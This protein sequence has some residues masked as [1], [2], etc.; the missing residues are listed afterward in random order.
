[1]NTPAIESR[2]PAWN[3][4]L[5]DDE[6]DVIEV[7]RMVMEDLVFEDRPLN[8][9]TAYSARDA[10]R[11]FA[12]QPDIALAFIDVVMETE[13]AGL[14]LV[15]YVRETLRNDRTRLI[16]RT[17]NPGAAPQG[18]VVRYL[19]IDDYKEKT[20]LT[21]DRLGTSVLTSLRSYRNLMAHIRVQEGLQAILESIDPVDEDDGAQ[22]AQLVAQCAAMAARSFGEAGSNG[23]VL[24]AGRLGV[25]ALGGFGRWAALADTMAPPALVSMIESGAASAAQGALRPMVVAEGLLLGDR[26]HPQHAFF[27]WLQG[28]GAQVPGDQLKVLQ[29]F[30]G[31]RAGALARASLRRDVILA[32]TEVL[33]R[34]C[35]AVEHR[36]KE[37]GAHIRRIARY[38]RSLAQ[39]L[40]LPVEEQRM[41]EMAAPLHDIGKVAIPDSILNKPGRLDADEWAL[42]QTHAEV[43]HR[44]LSHREFPVMQAAAEVAYHH[45]ERWDGTGYPRGLAGEAIPVSGRIVALVDVFDALLSRRAYKEPWGLPR[46]VEEL[47]RLQGTHFDPEL[48]DLLLADIDHFHAIFLDNPDEAPIADGG[49]LAAA[50]PGGA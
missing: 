20:E 18:D 33:C 47:R 24:S 42:M 25:R 26:P 46:V 41:L 3:V 1:M 45:H 44:L 40:G 27:L 15:K 7:S 36:S 34:L 30:L 9:L 39:R 19:E 10:R 17:G 38:A 23:M 32:Q 12:E 50:T 16:L 14:E 4:L 43:G 2:A 8:I 11:I 49:T 6:E 13:H 22:Y 37:T 35:E 5:V 31:H 29:L 28:A 21:A 48:V